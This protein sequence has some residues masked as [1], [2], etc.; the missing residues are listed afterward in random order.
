V[1]SRRTIRVLPDLTGKSTI[2]LE[3]GG[4]IRFGDRTPF[5]F[6]GRYASVAD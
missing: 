2:S 1:K 6:Q 4:A 3:A 5:P